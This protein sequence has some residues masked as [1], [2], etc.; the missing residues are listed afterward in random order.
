MSN[1]EVCPVCSGEVT[2][3]GRF[4]MK[5]EQVEVSVNKV[6]FK[7]VPQV[8]DW[9]IYFPCGC[10]RSKTGGKERGKFVK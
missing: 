2:M 4:V 9:T 6:E 8:G 1:K 3:P 5:A 7:L 10:K